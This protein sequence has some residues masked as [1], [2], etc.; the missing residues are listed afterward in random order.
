MSSKATVLRKS[1]KMPK[2]LRNKR[3]K[4]SPKAIIAR[5]ARQEK[6]ATFRKTRFDQSRDDASY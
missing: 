1:K 3:N 4:K 6:Q 5:L 2:G